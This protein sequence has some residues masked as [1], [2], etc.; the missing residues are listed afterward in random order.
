MKIYEHILLCTLLLIFSLLLGCEK[1]VDEDVV[2]PIESM[3]GQKDA[4]AM[5]AAVA[6]VQ[7]VR[8]ALMRYPAVSMENEYPRDTQIYDY[9]SLREI[10][11][12]ANLPTSM[13]DLM[14][15]PAF[16]INY[17]SDGLSF[18]FQVRAMTKNNAVIT[19]TERGVKR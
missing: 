19:A 9:D 11:V 18:S 4:A 15:D 13:A 6:N 12:S 17:S 10:L 16:G 5:E 3:Y 7:M 2:Q 14:W 1:T 8:S